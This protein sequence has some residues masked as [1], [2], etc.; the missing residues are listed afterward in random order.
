LVEPFRERAKGQPWAD[1]G[2]AFVTEALDAW[3]DDPFSFAK[4]PALPDAGWPH[5]DRPQVLPLRRLAPVLRGDGCSP[6]AGAQSHKAMVDASPVR[7]VAVVLSM[8]L[9]SLLCQILAAV[10][11]ARG[12][13]CQRA[14]CNPAFIF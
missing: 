5:D 13:V 7:G 14:L 3:Q 11:A 8:P 4:S 9:E 6:T 2:I 10:E 12:I 1:A